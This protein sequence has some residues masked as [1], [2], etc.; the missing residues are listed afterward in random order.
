MEQHPSIRDLPLELLL[1][2]FQ[3]SLDIS[4]LQ[5]DRCR[6]SLVCRRW[7]DI[8][9]KSACLWTDIS[10]YDSIEYIKR[11]LVKSANLP[12][13][14]HYIYRNPDNPRNTLLSYLEA[15]RDHFSRCRSLV[16]KARPFDTCGQ[17]FDDL[18]NIPAPRLESLV[19]EVGISQR[20]DPGA[21]FDLRRLPGM[22][23]FPKLR[24]LEISGIP[25]EISP[26]GLQ[27]N[28]FRSLNLVGVVN[29]EADQLLDVLR[30]SPR[31]E[32][33]G[34]GL[35]PLTRPSQPVLAPIHLPY[36]LALRLIYMPI[37]VSQFFLTTIRAPNC[38]ELSISS[39]F[40]ERPDDVVREKLFTSDTKHF[41]PVLQKLLTR[42]IFKDAHMYVIRWTN[43]IDFDLRLD[44]KEVDSVGRR[45]VWLAF[46][47]HSVEQ[48]EQTVHWLV[49]H[50]KRDMPKIPIRL[51]M[52][53]I[54]EVRLLD[55]FDSH[56]AITHLCT[57]VRERPGA[58]VGAPQPSPIFL[59]MAQ[60]TA[61]SW[62]LPD[63]E[64]FVY[65]PMSRNGSQHEAL[66]DMLRRRYGSGPKELD[67]ERIL[68]RP[69]R[70]MRIGPLLMHDRNFLGEVEKILPH[71]E[72]SVIGTDSFW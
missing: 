9:Q 51:F 45:I 4:T 39:K 72:V 49:G 58:P 64:V 57:R 41:S 23:T 60:P 24:R 54:R 59:H 63:L 27:L 65:D 47:L 20:W 7:R 69:L 62:P 53:G 55:V 18:Q 25:C 30:N 21:G 22:T 40:P 11:S 16:A 17:L 68:P 37:S 31:L 28:D 43:R 29:V 5:K 36:L 32:R 71:A 70:R 46:Q 34:L 42:G 66:L 2:I 44:G 52:D 1:T 67:S 26:P 3:W 35:S 12:I 38:S 50:L 19:L 14:L 13:D 6:L 48:I 61:S 10:A 56:M 15:V 33:L 8:V